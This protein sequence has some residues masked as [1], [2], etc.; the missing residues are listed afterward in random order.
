MP[1]VIARIVLALLMIPA[2][3][4]LYIVVMIIG[5]EVLFGWDEEAAF[6]FATVVT[7][8]FVAVFWILIWR[9]SIRWTAERMLLTFGAFVIAAVL[10]IG[11][12][13]MGALAIDELSFGIFLGGIVSMVGWLIATVFIWR[14]TRAERIARYS[15]DPK[16]LV[17]PACGY[18]MSELRSAQCPEC[19]AQYTI[20]QLINLQPGQEGALLD[21]AQRSKPA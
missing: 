12:G 8:C 1:R 18:S 3:F 9:G 6:T 20:Q 16:R 17:C 7:W 10:G 21:A 5:T 13:V 15:S 19:G 14:D 4:V 11:A 2:A